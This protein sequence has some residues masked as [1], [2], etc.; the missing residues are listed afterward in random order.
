MSTLPEITLIAA[1]ARNGVIGRDNGLPWKLKADMQHF[2][3]LT[4]GHPVIMGRKTWDSLGRPLPGRRNLVVTRDVHFRT[5]GAEIFN[6]P[7]AAVS[8]AASGERIFVIGGAQL[9][10]T[11]LPLAERLELTEV[12]ADVDGDA[13]FPL[14]DRSDF[15]EE[16]RDAR[17]ADADND[18]DFD[19]VSYRR[20]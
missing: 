16:R 7:A 8:A 20:R 2:R 12:W 14:F 15:I 3:T 1:V 9:Y 13:H 11:L 4:M 19:F 10:T 6:T 18:F 5:E 17:V